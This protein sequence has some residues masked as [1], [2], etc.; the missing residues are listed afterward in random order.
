MQDLYETFLKIEDRNILD[1][2]NI[3]AVDATPPVTVIIQQ[4]RRV[5]QCVMFPNPTQPIMETCD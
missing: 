1:L 3:L 2:D 5:M 4:T